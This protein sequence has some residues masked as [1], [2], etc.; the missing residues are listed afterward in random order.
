M[1]VVADDTR[2]EK[3]LL[4]QR[5]RLARRGLSAAAISTL[6][7]EICRHVCQWPVFLRAAT[8][9]SFMSLA[10]EVDTACINEAILY[11][12]KTLCIP[13]L[14]GPQGVMEPAVIADPAGDTKRGRYGLRVP[15]EDRLRL[16]SPRQLDLLLVPGVAFDRQGHR[17]GMGGGYYDRFIPRLA[18]AITV[19]VGFSLQMV[20]HVPTEKWDKPLHYVVSE[21]G[22]CRCG[23]P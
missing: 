20:A 5:L 15:R 1:S 16:L 22:L 10:D 7:R 17:L 6:S 11:Q 18:G 12:G 19:G 9:M 3:E 4:R 2:R 14:P 13:Y 23:M 8:V 21:Q